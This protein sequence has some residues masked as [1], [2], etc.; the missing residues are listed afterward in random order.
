MEH[1]KKQIAENKNVFLT[2]EKAEEF[3]S[4]LTGIQEEKTVLEE[5]YFV[6]RSKY[7]ANQLTMDEAMAKAENA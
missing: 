7:R 1:L 6:M 4:R 3:N 2:L 5:Q